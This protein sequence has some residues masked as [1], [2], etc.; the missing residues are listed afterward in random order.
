MCLSKRADSARR[1]AYAHPLQP[2]DEEED[3]YGQHRPEDGDHSG[4]DEQGY[5]RT[6]K[7]RAPATAD[8]RGQHDGHSFNHFGRA[9]GGDGKD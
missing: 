2:K 8:A 3:A 4:E 6:F 5:T 1:I 9:G 7:R